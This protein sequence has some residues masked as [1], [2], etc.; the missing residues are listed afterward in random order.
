ME[1]WAWTWQAYADVAIGL[2]HTLNIMALIRFDIH[3]RALQCSVVQLM[4]N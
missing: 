2:M 1:N 4:F 3:R